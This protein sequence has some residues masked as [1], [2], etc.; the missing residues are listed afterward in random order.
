MKPYARNETSPRT[1]KALRARIRLF[2]LIAVLDGLTACIQ[3]ED[4][5]FVWA[6]VS[7]ALMILCISELTELWAKP[8]NS[9]R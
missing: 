8:C 6:A 3:I 7:V 9:S 5:E 4:G 2:T 1:H